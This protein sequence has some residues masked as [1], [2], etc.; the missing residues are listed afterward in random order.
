[1]PT[2]LS[3]DI[4]RTSA[5]AGRLVLWEESARDGA[6]G[7]TLMNAEFRIRIARKQGQIFGV[8][9]ARHV[10]FAAG[11]PA[12]CGEEFEV[13]RRVALEVD[14]AVSPAAVCRATAADVRQAV[15]A[16]H[17]AARRR[18]MIVVPASDLLADV[19]LHRTARAML[20]LAPEL[21]DEAHA[22]DRTAGG[23]T[24]TLSVDV[25]LA[26]A[27]RADPVLLAELAE[28]VTAA[29][30]G[31]VVIADTIGDLLP[32]QTAR[33]FDRLHHSIG[34]QVVLASHLH[35]DLGLGLA[36]TLA[37]L[38]AGV[39]V[40][41]CS[42]LGLAERSGMVATEQLLF[43]LAYRPEIVADLLG[44]TDAPGRGADLWWAEPDLTRLPEIAEMV[45]ARTGL[46]LSVTTP[47]VGSGVGTIST[48]TPFV[49]PGAFQPFDP[50]RVLGVEPHVLLTQ[51]ASARVVQ[52]V[53][54]RLGF[55]PDRAQTVAALRWVKQEAYR[56]DQAVIPDEDLAGFLRDAGTLPGPVP[57]A[58]PGSGTSPGSGTGPSSGT[59][60]RAVS[61][62][63]APQEVR[64]ALVAGR[65]V[66]MPNPPPLTYV[67]AATTPTAVNQ[68]KRRP[69]DQEVA[70]WV[71]GD[72]L[73]GE[74][75]DLVAL[76]A[77]ERGFATWLLLE[78]RVTLLVPLRPDMDVPGWLSPAVRGGYALLFGARWA[79]VLPLLS[80]FRLLYVSS[81]N[82]TGRPPA[83]TATDAAAM[84]GPDIPI[85]DA[86]TITTDTTTTET[87][88]TGTVT[89]EIVTTG[90]ASAGART[91]ATTMLRLG[92]DGTL[93]LVR[94]GAHDRP[95]GPGGSA[96]LP[97]VDYLTD[98]QA[99]FRATTLLPRSYEATL[100]FDHGHVL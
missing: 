96:A 62:A 18:V 92:A 56:R 15:A 51:L 38:R 61:A 26:D 50:R 29:G 81:A 98:V 4:V 14:G 63:T 48:G 85:L 88:T 93:G 65:A 46:P 94:H 53:A 47:I 6:Q 76:A 10:V 33:L 80:A 8:H 78:E 69:V 35:N 40:A 73:L 86:D 12:V 74:L 16:V 49:H 11:F 25:C 58:G 13:T 91:G 27:P 71:T 59:E 54:E 5:Q 100:S 64:A 23:V 22:A 3:T 67:V 97:V 30:A 52:A 55:A 32:T 95:D 83:A 1:M 34:D 89:T 24:G 2:D 42:W 82:R 21:V 99:R 45:S 60:G 77:P 68:A 20:T 44:D 75:A 72:A 9:G 37:A 70:V 36:N 57:V 87:V 31:V 39:R 84:F 19:M 66:I 79:P 28:R 17:A 7:K 43:L 90:T 41:A